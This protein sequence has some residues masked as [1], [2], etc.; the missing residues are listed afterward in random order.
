MKFT[1]TKIFRVLESLALALF[2]TVGTCML[3]M[4][5]I[6]LLV[7]GPGDSETTMAIMFTMPLYPIIFVSALGV[8]CEPA[9]GR[10]LVRFAS[11]V[12]FGLLLFVIVLGWIKNAV[13]A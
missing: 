13:F 12:L 4:F 11:I 1:D 7:Q 6:M 9:V 3:I 2:L 5:V 8:S 10:R